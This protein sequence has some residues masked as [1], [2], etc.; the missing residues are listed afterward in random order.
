MTDKQIKE[1]IDKAVAGALAARD[2]KE[3]PFN[4]DDY[5]DELD[6]ISERIDNRLYDFDRWLEEKVEE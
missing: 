3:K 1:Y 4:I 6:R 5:K 2:G